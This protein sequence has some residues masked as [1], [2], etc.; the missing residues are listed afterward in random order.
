MF[1]HVDRRATV[2]AAE[3]EALSEAEA[4]QDDR[5]DDADRGGGREQSN[6]ESADT[7]ERHGYDECV[8]AAD[9]VAES[10]EEQCTERTHGKTGR[11][12][13]QCEDEG[14]RRVHAGKELRGQNRRQGAVDIKVVPL[15]YCTERRSEDD[16][17]LLGCHSTLALLTR[18]H[19]CHGASPFVVSC[20]IS[21]WGQGFACP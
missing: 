10:A 5:R 2:F 20:W 1:A 6:E 8:F 13:E 4:D 21:F 19:C 12:G 3:R 17:P 11:E 14:R 16:H 18:S 9:K 15:E 7:H